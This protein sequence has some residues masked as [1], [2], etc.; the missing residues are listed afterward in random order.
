MWCPYTDREIDECESNL[1]HIL[2][3]ALGGC[4]AFT[5]GVVRSANSTI[6]SEIDGAL[7]NDPLIAFAHSG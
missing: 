4:D 3:I 6:G 1:E 2:P 5:I 7:A